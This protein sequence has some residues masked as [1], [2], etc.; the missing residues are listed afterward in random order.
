[1]LVFDGGRGVEMSVFAQ[2]AEMVN[3]IVALCACGEDDSGETITKA[4]MKLEDQLRRA[5]RVKHYSLKTKESYVSWYR[6]YVLWA[7]KRHPAEMGAAEVEGFL[8]W[9]MT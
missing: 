5:I 3:K 8:T 4:R 9:L 1:M 2:M 7:G 6:R